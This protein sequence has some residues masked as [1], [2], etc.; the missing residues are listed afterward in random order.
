M[1]FECPQFLFKN[2]CGQ[3]LILTIEFGR[4][5]SGTYCSTSNNNFF[6]NFILYSHFYIQM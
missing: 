1:I 4:L 2:L 3:I 6:L 5:V